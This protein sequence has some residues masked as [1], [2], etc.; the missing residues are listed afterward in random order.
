MAANAQNPAGVANSSDQVGRNMMDHSGFHCTFLADQPLWLGRGPA[1][2]SCMVGP[3]DGAFRSQ[4]SANK[5]I[6]NNISRVAPAAAQ[7]LKLGLTGK[8]LQDEFGD[9]PSSASTSR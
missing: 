8:A 6:L 9:A 3:R 4:Y 5:I 2:S 1:Q 7:A